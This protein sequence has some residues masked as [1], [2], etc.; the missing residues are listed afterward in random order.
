MQALLPLVHGGELPAGAD[1]S[2]RAHLRRCHACQRALAGYVAAGAALRHAAAEPV[3]GERFFESLQASTLDAVAALPLRM[4]RWDRI[5][6]R[7]AVAAALVAVGV[8]LAWLL[9]AADEAPGARLLRQPGLARHD[10]P[11]GSQGEAVV[12]V[13]FSPHAQGLLGL[14]RLDLDPRW[15]DRPR[16]PR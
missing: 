6:R 3:V 16:E 12:P 10:T 7:A 8:G 14:R 4:R 2:A 9:L 15:T 11:R 13:S 5:A 1:A